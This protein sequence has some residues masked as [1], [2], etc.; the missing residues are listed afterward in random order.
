MI[1]KGRS[2]MSS[3]IVHIALKV[4]D[5]ESATRFYEAVFGFRR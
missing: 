4:N 2:V 1:S 3:K 5:L